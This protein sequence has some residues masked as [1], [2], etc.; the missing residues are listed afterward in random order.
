[1]LVKSEADEGPE[2]SITT[3]RNR[4]LNSS[5]IISPTIG[6]T[7]LPTM[8]VMGECGVSRIFGSRMKFFPR[9]ESP[10]AEALPV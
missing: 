2:F 7:R 4:V 3:Q 1:M 10:G 8:V 5:P 9:F 6:L